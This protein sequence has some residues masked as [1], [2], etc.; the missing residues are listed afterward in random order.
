MKYRIKIT[1]Y[2]NGRKEYRA[3]VKAAIGWRGLDW[4]GKAD[5]A[6]SYCSH[7]RE[8]ALHII[9]KHYVGNSKVQRIEFEYITK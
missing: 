6:Y 2:A 4:D 9:D 1:T 7:D 5:L 3:Y 8:T